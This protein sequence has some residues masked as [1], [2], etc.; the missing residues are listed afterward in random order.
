M[1]TPPSFDPEAMARATAAAIGLPIAPHQMPGIVG[2]LRFAAFA[3]GLVM[4]VPLT[5]ED[6]QAPLF[7]AGP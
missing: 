2:S 4:A 6:E 7:E 1:T 3:A 5:K